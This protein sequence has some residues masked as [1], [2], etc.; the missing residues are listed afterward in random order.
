MSPAY[1]ESSEDVFSWV[2]VIMYLPKEPSARKAIT[3]AFDRYRQSMDFL[4]EEF[5]GR[6]HWA[7]LEL[8]SPGSPDYAAQLSRMRKRVRAVYPIESFHHYK[9]ALDPNNVLSNAFVD[10][11][12]VPSPEE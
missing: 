4:V 7:K 8:P 11:L 12:L 3:E 6:A 1:S 9:T 5:N 2:G 10:A